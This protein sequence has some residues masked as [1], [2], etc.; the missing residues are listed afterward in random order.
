MDALNLILSDSAFL[1]FPS[2]SFLSIKHPRPPARPPPQSHVP[3]FVF[4]NS[5]Q[6][7]VC[8]MHDLGGVGA[9]RR[10]IDVCWL[11]CKAPQCDS[12]VQPQDLDFFYTVRIW[13]SL[14]FVRPIALDTY[15]HSV[16]DFRKLL[17][18]Q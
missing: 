14:S 12:D 15:V 2:P 16:K 4:A 18:M 3:S 11:A 17:L 9:G 7:C 6:F 1:F 5:V 8:Q 10:Q 13:S